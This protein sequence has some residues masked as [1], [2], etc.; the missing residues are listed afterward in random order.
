MS[1]EQEQLE[2]LQ[3]EQTDI[4]DGRRMKEFLA[5]PAVQRILKAAEK[6]F[7]VDFH[8]AETD[9]QR[10]NVWAGMR[11]LSGLLTSLQATLD[12]SKLAMHTRTIRDAA[13]ARS[14]TRPP[15]K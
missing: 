15:R 6:Q 12:N 13:E 4:D 9:D 14:D 3:K 2:M 7:V 8:D 11:A 5:D 1:L 10:R